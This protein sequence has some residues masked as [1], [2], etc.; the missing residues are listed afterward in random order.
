MNNNSNNNGKSINAT[1]MNPSSM[2]IDA[3]TSNTMIPLKGQH[4]EARVFQRLR[5]VGL[6]DD[7]DEEPWEL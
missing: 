6:S 1:A 3:N 4:D 5:I 7:D 2:A